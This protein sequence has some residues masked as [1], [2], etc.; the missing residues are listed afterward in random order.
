MNNLKIGNLQLNTCVSLAPMAG[1]TDYVL[2]SLIRTNSQTCLLTTEMVSSEALINES[3]CK[4]RDLISE[5]DLIKRDKNHSPISYQLTGHKPLLMADAAKLISD[6]ADIID[7]NMGCPVKKVV[8]G[9]DGC[10]LMKNPK[11]AQDIVKAIKET[12]SCPVTVKFRLGYT[13]DEMN[14]VEFGQAMQDAGA[15]MI[16]L[17]ARTKKQMYSG[18]ADW[19]KIADLKRNVDIPV[20]ANGDIKS[21]ED[22]I[23]CLE[24][25]QANGIA[26]GRASM[27]DVT[28]IHRIEHFFNTGEILSAPSLE[29]NINNLKT[30]LLKEIELRGEDIGVKFS[31]KFYPFYISGI[32]NAAKFRAEIVVENDYKK[33]LKHLDEVICDTFHPSLF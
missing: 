9:Q 7:I 5:N 29:E 4:K 18:I 25:S 13:Q 33:I 14:F 1:I 22:A 20:F 6:R 8:G 2:R 24:L 32:R 10:A 21:V 15:D 19:E 28:L 3:K 16:T 12:V 23:K 30:L 26:I 27:G 11:L 17:H 31:R